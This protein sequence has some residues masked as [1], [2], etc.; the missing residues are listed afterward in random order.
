MFQ[1]V[2]G[3]LQT[4]EGSVVGSNQFHKQVRSVQK[5]AISISED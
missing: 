4:K 3:S 1:I 2:R 5:R